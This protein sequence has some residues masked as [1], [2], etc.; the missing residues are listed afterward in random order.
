MPSATHKTPK[1]SATRQRLL[2]VGAE[3]CQTV[4]YNAF[5][6]RHLAD[7]LGIKTATIHYYFPSKADLG[8]DLMVDYRA[9]TAEATSE[10]D[11]QGLGAVEKLRRF[12]QVF[13]GTFENGE[14]LCLCGSFAA[15]YQTL[16]EAIQREVRGYFDDNE[17][18]LARVLEQGR[19]QGELDFEG[20]PGEVAKTFFTALEGA[21]LAARAFSDPHRLTRTT[22]YWLALLRPAA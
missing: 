22:D 17:R 12:A 10:L 3:L 9:A 18:W 20:E 13:V 19:R 5:S 7:R 6:Y 11:R 1:G 21:M 16:P 8:R 4:G 15:D 2:D 14:R